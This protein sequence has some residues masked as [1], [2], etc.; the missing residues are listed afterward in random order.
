VLLA[1]LENTVDLN[2]NTMNRSELEYCRSD[3][4]CCRS[5]LVCC[6]SELYVVD[7][8][9]YVVDLILDLNCMCRSDLVLI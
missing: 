6:G 1:D 7:L 8:I 3:L 5:D 9:L 4:V 2:L